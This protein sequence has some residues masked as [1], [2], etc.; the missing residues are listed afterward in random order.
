MKETHLTEKEIQQYVLERENCESSII[1]HI[2]ACEECKA[3]LATYEYI[4]KE[5]RNLQK[6]VLDF[7][8]PTLVMEQIEERKTNCP[9]TGVSIYSISTLSIIF[10][11]LI[12]LKY[13]V[14]VF[15]QFTTIG[16]WLIITTAL[17]IVVFHSFE[18][19]KKY[20]NQ[21]NKLDLL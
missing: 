2:N 5:V 21:M 9:R 1:E 16:A 7:D 13:V 12:F 11:I 20:Q 10:L 3:E 14:P 15:S 18:S 6:P 17:I 19:Y 8:L 4:F